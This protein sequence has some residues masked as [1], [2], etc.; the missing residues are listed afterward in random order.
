MKNRVKLFFIL[1][2]V[3][4]L[5]SCKQSE[6]LYT[7]GLCIQLPG[8]ASR[9]VDPNEELNYVLT[10]STA[11]DE[12][13]EKKK[14]KSGEII[15]VLISAGLYTVDLKGYALD[16]KEF[17]TPFLYGSKKDVAV[18]AGEVTDVELKLKRSTFKV[19]FDGNPNEKETDQSE[20][21]NTSNENT[22]YKVVEVL[23][24][25]TVA[26][27]EEIPELK[28]KAFKCWLDESEKEFNF[29]TLI[30]RNIVLH[31]D[32]EDA[33]EVY[34][35]TFDVNGGT[36]TQESLSVALNEDVIIPECTLTAPANAKFAGW[37]TS[38]DEKDVYYV[39]G[40]KLKVTEDVTLYAVWIS[41]YKITFDANEGTGTQESIKESEGK[42][43]IL[44]ECTFTAPEGYEF[45]GWALTADEEDLYYLPGDKL[46][47]KEDMTLYA[48]WKII[49]QD[50]GFEI[51]SLDYSLGIKAS[52]DLLKVILT[53]QT[54]DGE[55][56]EI[57]E[58]SDLEIVWML[59]EATLEGENKASV[60]IDTTTNMFI[61]EDN[62]VTAVVMCGS[63]MVTYTTTFKCRGIQ[64]PVD[65]EERG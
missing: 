18:L 51:S 45:Y 14:A 58:D 57:T 60:T 55:A 34:T 40:N 30:K 63:E 50:A 20:N 39:P 19:T 10:V 16:D 8:N 4:T 31:P 43:I 61:R 29:A 41:D 37:A 33:D 52:E 25:D 13:I 32:W 54:S 27:P 22:F 26:K 5:F 48:V 46:E 59:N 49:P 21:D 36:G 11:S 35:I 65:E 9:A 2:T 62:I 44:P 42:E 1:M 7:S 47:L 3:F 28:G 15:S 53:L 12:V 6:D 64:V 23:Y 24:C 17:E 56:V 38:A